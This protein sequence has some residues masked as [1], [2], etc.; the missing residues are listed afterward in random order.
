MQVAGEE[1]KQLVR[2]STNL[3]DLVSETVSLK[4]LHGGRSYVGLC[5][6]H[7]DH[8]PSFNVYPDRQSY[9]C[10]VCD[11][12]GDCFSWVMKIEKVSFPEAL[13]SLA[14]RARLEIPRRSPQAEATAGPGRGEA[15]EVAEWAAN[16]MH[17]TL[18]TSPVAQAARDYVSKRRL[19]DETVRNFRLGYHPD[20]RYWL[21]DKARGRFSTAQLVAAGIIRPRDGGQGHSTMD[22]ADRLVFPVFDEKGRVVAFG[23]RVLP[24]RNDQNRGKYWNSWE[25]SIFQKRRTTFAF[26]KARETIRRQKVA[27]VVEGYMDCIACHQA[28]VTSAIATLGTALTEDHVRFLRRFA[29][30]VVL[31]YDSD[32]AGQ[33]AAERSISQFLAQDLD[34]RILNVPSGK[35]PADYLEDHSREEFLKLTESALEAWDYKLQAVVKRSGTDSIASRQQVLTQMLEFL[36]SAPGLAGTVR[37]DLILR[38]V[39]W[40]VQVDE[41]VARQQLSDLRQAARKRLQLRS[42]AESPEKNTNRSAPASTPSPTTPS[43]TRSGSTSAAI[44]KAERDL[45]E[46]ILTCPE[47]IDLIRHHIGP[48]DFTDTRHRQLLELCIDLWKEEGELPETAR[49]ISAADSDTSLLSLINAVL[50]SAEEKGIFRLMAAGRDPSTAADSTPAYLDNVLGPLIEQREQ[51]LRQTSRQLMAQTDKPRNELDEETRNALRKLQQ[52]RQNQ[53]GYPT[54]PK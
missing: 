34:L 3:V 45:L 38:T 50:D 32:D 40:K 35:D 43:P 47:T 23:G 28:G 46:I 37:E 36:N 42:P 2:S 5:P 41:R 12:G 16:L 31:V 52:F 21:Q 22:L 29:E 9:R 10:W 26:D 33:R 24:G 11:E 8:N 14:K 4:P 6:F 51:H 48:D 13:E 1:F 44:R 49:L 17:Q 20:D 39:C 25:S 15:L 27:I 18:R 53:M 54:T 7:E 30:R 19:T